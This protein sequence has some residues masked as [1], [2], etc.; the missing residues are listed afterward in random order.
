MSDR[1][2]YEVLGLTPSADGA[3]VDQGYW[4]LARK[5][6]ALSATNPRGHQLLDDLNEAYGVLGNPRLRREY[7]AFRDE[8][9][10][11][12]GVIRPVKSKA[13]GKSARKAGAAGSQ[14][15]MARPRI[16]HWR[17]YAT[18]AVIAALAFAGAW[19]G[20]NPAFVIAA[21]VAGLAFS[22]TPSLKMSSVRLKRQLPQVNIT[23][24]S[25]PFSVPEIKAPKLNLTKLGELAA[26]EDKDEPLDL[27]ELR[28]STAAIIA[29][30]RKSMGLRAIEPGDAPTTTLVEIVQSEREVEE[31][32]P[33]NA[34][35][36]ILRGAHKKTIE[37]NQSS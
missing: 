1:D 4:H 28:A 27:D 6:Q 13:K 26:H 23:I 3:M 29:R 33:L 19:Q 32:E 17:T 12:G 15:W 22:L 25:I 34:V 7:D 16:E 10:V 14:T 18:S 31:S 24:P 2:Y 20:V 11:E 9:L 37:T 36:E 8:V 30:W 21:L 35:L 5:Y